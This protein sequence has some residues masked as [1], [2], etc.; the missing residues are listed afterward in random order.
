MAGKIKGIL[1]GALAGAILGVLFA[2]RKG[3]KTRKRI[4]RRG[5]GIRN[6]IKEGF[7]RIEDKIDNELSNIR[8]KAGEPMMERD[9]I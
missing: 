6:A 3:S 5:A 7:G 1:A 4:A 8:E 9:I 2:P